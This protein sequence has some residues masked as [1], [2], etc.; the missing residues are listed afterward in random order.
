VWI[1][2]SA[3]DYMQLFILLVFLNI[4]FKSMSTL[5][6]YI[7]IYIS[8]KPNVDQSNVQHN[9]TNTSKTRNYTNPIWLKVI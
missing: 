7:Y 5:Y 1:L 2:R 6:I 9:I 8:I 3:K 4:N